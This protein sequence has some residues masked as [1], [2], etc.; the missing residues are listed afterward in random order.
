MSVVRINTIVVGIDGSAESVSAALW[1]AGEARRR[2][3]AV[4][5]VH[6]FTMPV[7]AVPGSEISAGDLRNALHKEG[8][9]QLALAAHKVGAQYPDVPLTTACFGDH[10]VLALQHT[11]EHAL[12]AV[13]GAHGQ[14]SFPD[15][16]LGSI[17]RQAAGHLPCPVVVVRRD[18][19]TDAV[20]MR[21]PVLV[22]LDGSAHSDRAL[23]FA[24]EEA[25]W[26]GEPLIAAHSW[27][28]FSEWY[29]LSV[30]VPIS[31]Q[32]LEG[33][34]ARLL[35]EQLA[36]WSEKYPDVTVH[37]TLR[38]GDP[39]PTLLDIAEHSVDGLRPPS[40]LVVGCRGRGGF[41]GL[42]LGSNS[43]HLIAHAPCPVA[44]TPA[45]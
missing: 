45:H 8:Q 14:R 44:V 1:A 22:G 3:A 27:L 40:L 7:G 21:G 38:A 30:G 19:R 23:A 5:L 34:E 31:E 36:G 35:S 20:R 29:A 16:L 41:R 13:V 9:A 4:R 18:P 6:G 26:R 33:R 32:P 12:F 2:D 11:C 17:A 15:T 39:T 43:Q 42:V 25:S 24:M 28:D 10:P 37:E